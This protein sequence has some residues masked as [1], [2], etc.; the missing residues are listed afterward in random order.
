MGLFGF[1]RRLFR[2]DRTAPSLSRTSDSRRSSEFASSASGEA[3][4]RRIRLVPLRYQ[5]SLVRTEPQ[6]ELVTDGPPYRFAHL[7][8]DGS[9][10]LDLSQ[11]GDP[12]WLAHFDLPLLTTP[13]DLA[14]FCDLKLGKLAWLTH[15]FDAGGRPARD[16]D[17][18]YHFHWVRKTRGGHRLIESPK[19]TLK[20]VQLRI[21]REIL[22]SVPAH[23]A[24][25]GFVRG[26]SIR[27]NAAPHVGKRVIIKFDLENFYP[28]VKYSRIVAIF[29]S[30]GY[31]REVAL[32]LARLTTSAIPP[33]LAFPGGDAAAVRTYYARHLPQAL[34]RRLRWP[35]CPRSD[36]IRD[37]QDWRVRIIFSTHGMR[38]ISR[39]PDRGG[40]YP[41]LKEFIPL[42]TQIIRD[43]RFIVHLAKRKVLRNNQQQ[44]VAGVVVNTKPNVSRRDFDRLKAI[45]HNCLTQGPATQNR[46]Q[47]P[48]LAAH[49]LGRIAH[50]AH[51]NPLRGAKLRVIYEQI[52]WSR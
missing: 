38:T 37:W 35:T 32:W 3:A 28:S 12:R 41:A 50:V 10:H 15:R 13:E 22:D 20:A 21:L 49:L 4:A 17:A 40:S 39:F 52:D 23:G 31:S 46:E 45:L 7:A 42:A 9:G 29:R 30:L 5:S 51:L 36:S 8:V 11:D 2:W 47:H 1:L 48:D 24:A 25:H 14:N 16:R 27:S 18:H 26:R 44:S 6:S 34:P 19:Q 43:E 33:G